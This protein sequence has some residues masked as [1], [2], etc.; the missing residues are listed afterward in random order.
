M[1]VIKRQGITNTISSYLGIAIGFVNLIMIQPHFLTKEELGLTRILYSFSLIVATFVPLGIGNATVRYFPLFKDK[2][3]KH[4]GYFAF[5]SIF[6]MIGFLV[7]SLVLWLGRDFI[8]NQYRTQSPLF[9]DYFNWVFPLIFF[10]AFIAVFS[11]YCNS[12]FKSTVPAFLNDVGVRLLTIGVVTVYFNRWV[13]LDVFIALFAGIYAIQLIGLLVY[14]FSFEKPGLKIDWKIFREKKMFELIRYGLLLWFASVASIG[15]K[16]FDSIMIGKYMPLSFVG[17]YTIAAFVPTVIEAP[18]NAIDKIAASKIS[19]AWAENDHSQIREIYRKSSLYM[20]LIGG[21]IFLNININ[22]H[23]LLEF[24]PGG[25]QQGEIVVYIISIG[26]LFNM[27]TGLNS[28]ILFNSER[29]KLGAL[30]LIL[31]AVIIL[32]LQ[33]LLIPWK[34]IAGAALATCLASLIYN[35]MLFLSV[36]K[37]FNLQPFGKENLKV[38]IALAVCGIVAWFSPHVEGRILDLVIRTTIVST[39][40]FLMIYFQ[41]VVPEFHRYLPWEKKS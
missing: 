5:M 14:I 12:N 2:D 31:L 30:F 18:L 34:G 4:H 21:F 8:L 28:A 23:T 6:P 38:L 20:F 39:L 17:I 13:S 9:L 11:I 41:K 24:L 7:A 40:Y 33:M 10:N 1:G 3:R 37:H 35:S 15:L 19:F 16:Y 27:A 29:Y 22:I 32:V 36:W 25:Y 26:T